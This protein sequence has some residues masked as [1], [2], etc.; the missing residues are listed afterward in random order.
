[1]KFLLILLLLFSTVWGQKRLAVAV[2]MISFPPHIQTDSQ[3]NFTGYLRDLMDSWAEDDAM[4]IVYEVV[5][6][7]RIVYSLQNR[8]LDVRIP[9]NP[10]WDG[11]AKEGLDIRYSQPATRVHGGYVRLADSPKIS[12]INDRPPVIGSMSGFSQHLISDQLTRGKLSLHEVNQNTS[13]MS[14]LQRGR[15]DAIFGDVPAL[16]HLGESMIGENSVVQCQELP[17][18]KSTYHLSAFRSHKMIERFDEWLQSEQSQKRLEK[19][20]KKYGL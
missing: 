16:I 15:V 7:K 3:G 6:V 12:E 14:L 9:D 19:L 11:K 5:P 17:S 8:K 4:S 18:E 10:V 2:E 20:K 1:M 13:L